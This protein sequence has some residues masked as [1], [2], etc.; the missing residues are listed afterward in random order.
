MIEAGVRCDSVLTSSRIRGFP[1]VYLILVLPHLQPTTAPG[2]A[3]AG[4][5]AGT[6]AVVV[7]VVVVVPLPYRPIERY[8]A[9]LA[10]L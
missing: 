8:N 9:F 6:E 3:A 7:V 4:A 10:E 2:P 5:G 1:T